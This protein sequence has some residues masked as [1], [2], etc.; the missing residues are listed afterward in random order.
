MWQASSPHGAVAIKAFPRTH[1]DSDRAARERRAL[2][3]VR[4]CPFIVELLG[5]FEAAC[6][7]PDFQTASYLC[8]CL[9][10]LQFDLYE[11]IDTHG[12][13][14]EAEAR[15]YAACVVIAVEHIHSKG[16]TPPAPPPP[17]PRICGACVSCP[18]P[19]GGAGECRRRV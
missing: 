9:E 12:E 11:L 6:E 8:L 7:R 16:C 2:Q 1:G 13:L 10:L 3:A 14:R 15:F 5:S 19:C 18:L 17:C 4:G